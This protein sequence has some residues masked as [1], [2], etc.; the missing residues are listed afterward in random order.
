MGQG[1]MGSRVMGVYGVGGPRVMGSGMV[2][3]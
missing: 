3:V 1:V 2:G